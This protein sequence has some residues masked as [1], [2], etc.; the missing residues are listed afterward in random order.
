MSD[1]SFD[2]WYDNR[3]G[4]TTM[5]YKL[6]FEWELPKSLI[7]VVAQDKTKITEGVKRAEVLDYPSGV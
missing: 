6:R 2:L 7:G 4:E 1:Y 5:A 3:V